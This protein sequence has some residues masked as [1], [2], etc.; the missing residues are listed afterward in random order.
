MVAFD[1]DILSEIL[2][3]RAKYVERASR[4]PVEDQAV[5]V[6]V[7]EEIFRGRLNSIR[8]A[9]SGVS[10]TTLEQA[11]DR[12]QDDVVRLRWLRFLRFDAAA[13]EK[14]LEFRTARSSRYS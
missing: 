9:G 6:V 13:H 1:A 10:K 8:C 3:S 5:P 14:F 7:V 11:Y 4:I 2:R 12:F